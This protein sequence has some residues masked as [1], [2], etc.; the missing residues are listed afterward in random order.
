MIEAKNNEESATQTVQMSH[1]PESED[2]NEKIDEAILEP[3]SPRMMDIKLEKKSAKQ[4]GCNK[5]S[6]F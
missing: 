1:K 3:I 4:D 2:R 5:C 6:L